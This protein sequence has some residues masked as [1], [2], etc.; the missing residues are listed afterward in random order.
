MSVFKPIKKKK[1]MTTKRVVE[2]SVNL[3][4]SLLGKKVFVQCARFFYEGQM[5]AINGQFLELKDTRTVH[6]T[7]DKKSR[8]DNSDWEHVE[9]HWG[10]R[11]L[12]SLGSIEVICE[13][14]KP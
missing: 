12:I 2:D 3:L 7:G 10:D 5:T 9:K 13:L 1:K 4:D 6:S 8:K 11:A 14:S